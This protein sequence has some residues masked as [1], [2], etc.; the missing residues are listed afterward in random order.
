[1]NSAGGVRN[2]VLVVCFA[3]YSL[4]CLLDREAIRLRDMFRVR[5]WVHCSTWRMVR[6]LVHPDTINNNRRFLWQYAWNHVARVLSRHLVNGTVGRMSAYGAGGSALL[7]FLTGT[8]G[9]EFGNW[10]FT[11][12]VRCFQGCPIFFKNSI[13]IF[14]QSLEMMIFLGTV[15]GFVPKKTHSDVATIF[16]ESLIQ[17][18]Q[19]FLGK[20]MQSQLRSPT[21]YVQLSRKQLLMRA[22]CLSIIV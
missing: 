5:L 7:P 17:L 2:G 8:N 22:I 12:F 18:A 21:L 19:D 3:V 6:L 13:F 20:K 4:W 15:W 16:I 9:F 11:T 14:G 1:M 10:E